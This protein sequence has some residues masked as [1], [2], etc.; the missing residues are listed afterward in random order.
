MVTIKKLHTIWSLH[1]SIN[2]VIW[3]SYDIFE[4]KAYNTIFGV[5]PDVRTLGMF[6]IDDKTGKLCVSNISIN[7]QKLSSMGENTASYLYN[8]HNGVI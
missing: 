8:T 7:N 4:D 2:Y 6:I 5:S 3:V 1:F